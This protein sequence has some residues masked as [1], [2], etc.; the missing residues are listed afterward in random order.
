MQLAI[1]LKDFGHDF[2]VF[3]PETKQS[4]ENLKVDRF[5]NDSVFGQIVACDRE[6]KGMS[7]IDAGTVEFGNTITIIDIEEYEYESE[8]D[9]EFLDF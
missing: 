1:L 4:I 8:M 3:I 9:V 2:K 7:L 5:L 6:T